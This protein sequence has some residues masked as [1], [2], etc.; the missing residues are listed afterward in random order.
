MSGTHIAIVF[1]HPSSFMFVALKHWVRLI[2]FVFRH[3]LIIFSCAFYPWTDVSRGFNVRSFFVS[4]SFGKFLRDFFFVRSGRFCRCGLVW[5]LSREVTYVGTGLW[6]CERVLRLRVNGHLDV[7][8]WAFSFW[9]K[10]VPIYDE[11]RDSTEGVVR[12]Q[13]RLRTS[14]APPLCLARV[15]VAGVVAMPF[16]VYWSKL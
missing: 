16:F 9:L 6:A 3:L 8:E 15:Q 12:I 10:Q 14:M 13:A 7:L 11:S 2:Q 4:F 5:Y 1:Q